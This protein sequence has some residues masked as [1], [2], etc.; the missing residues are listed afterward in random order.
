M[1]Q[2]QVQVKKSR[3]WRY[4]SHRRV[5]ERAVVLFDTWRPD[6][7]LGGGLVLPNKEGNFGK[8]SLPSEEVFWLKE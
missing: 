7:Y 3:S 1:K 8:S 6:L 4:T 2:A 5:P